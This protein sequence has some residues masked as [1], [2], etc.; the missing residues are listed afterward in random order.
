MGDWR[1]ALSEI[2]LNQ[3]NTSDLKIFSS[4]G[5]KFYK[6]NI[7][8]DAVSRQNRGEK[9]IIGIGSYETRDHLLRSLKTA[10]RLPHFGYQ[11]NKIN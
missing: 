1:V 4:E 10:T 2:I 8:F 11:Y 5:L 9:A 3:V 6:K 7:T